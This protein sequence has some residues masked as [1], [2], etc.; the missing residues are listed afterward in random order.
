M[1]ILIK[2]PKEILLEGEYVIFK[3]DVSEEE[4]WKISDEDSNYELINGV[5]IIHS[6]ESEEHEDIFSHLNAIF[7]YYL[8]ETGIGR[9]YGSRFVMRLSEKWNPEPDLLVVLSSNYKNVTATRLEGPADLIVEILSKATRETDLEKKLP[10]YLEAGVKEVWIIDPETKTIAL[11]SS[12]G[13]KAYPDPN[14]QQEINSDILKE[15]HLRV[16]WI[17]DRDKFS[18]SKI[19]QQI[20]KKH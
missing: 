5:L 8:Q 10:K 11:H 20:M 3:P 12:K 1:A 17:W 19:I 14:S 6:P 15:I 2:A 4:F 13:T 16:Q 7:R 9:V 18:S